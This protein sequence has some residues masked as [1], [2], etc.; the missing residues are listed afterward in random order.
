MIWINVLNTIGISGP[1]TGTVQLLSNRHLALENYQRNLMLDLYNHGFSDD[2]IENNGLAKQNQQTNSALEKV[3]ELRG[4]SPQQ[5]LNALSDPSK[6][7]NYDFRKPGYIREIVAGEAAAEAPELD[8]LLGD[9]LPDVVA[10]DPD[11]IYEGVEEADNMYRIL[12]EKQKSAALAEK[13]LPLFRSVGI[14]TR[15]Y[16]RLGTIE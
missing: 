1:Q 3:E 7:S 4:Y 14:H 10:H 16:I 5:I 9:A 8:E 6:D 2:S 11:H 15:N 12:K 13:L